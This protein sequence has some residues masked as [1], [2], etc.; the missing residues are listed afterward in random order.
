VIN[1]IL[2]HATVAKQVCNS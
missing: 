2:V 1:I